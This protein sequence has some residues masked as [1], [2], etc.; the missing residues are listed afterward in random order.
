MTNDAHLYTA[1]AGIRGF[2]CNQ[3]VTPAFAKQ[4]RAL[5]QLFVLRYVRRAQRHSYD[6]TAPEIETILDAGLG[7]AVVQHVAPPPWKPTPALGISYGQIAAEEVHRLGLPHGLMVACDLEGVRRG[8]PAIDVADYCN[9]WHAQVARAGF[10]PLLYVGYDPGL[11][12]TELYYHLRFTRYWSALNLN[13]DLYPAVR[14]VQLRQLEES[15]AIDGDVVQ[16][17]KLGSRPI[18]LA[19]EGWAGARR[20]A[21]ARHQATR[22]ARPGQD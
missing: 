5:G 20:G 12:A 17:D 15:Q 21:G 4:R 14:G 13:R 1:A 2:D 16:T 3:R 11:T 6:L 8:T 18:F 7:L 22:R 19:R 9:A 10:T